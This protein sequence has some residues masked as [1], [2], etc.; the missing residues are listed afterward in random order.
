MDIYTSFEQVS[1]P[2]EKLAKLEI[3][4]NRSPEKWDRQSMIESL[5]A[6]ARNQGANAIVI[7]GEA[8][9]VQRHPDPF[10]ER[11]PIYHR[12]YYVRCVTIA[13]KY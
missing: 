11:S 13:Y 6:K 9:T 1:K 5:I 2:Y 7:T 8:E 10:N 12:Y 3:S 4:D